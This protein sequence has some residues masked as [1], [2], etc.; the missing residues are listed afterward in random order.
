MFYY[1]RLNGE[2]LI[3]DKK[4]DIANEISEDCARE[5]K[6]IVYMLTSMEPLHSRMSFCV[7][8]PSLAFLK[9]EGLKLLRKS[10]S[11]SASLPGWLISKIHSGEVCSVNT[12]Y[13][14]WQ[15]ALGYSNPE[16]WRINVVGLGDVGGTLVTGLR[17]LGGEDISKIGLYD[18]DINKVKRWVFEAG[19]IY[20]PWKGDFPDV[21]GIDED[22]IFDCD[23]FVFCVSVG[24]PPVGSGISDV[25]MAQFEGNSRVVSSYAE[26]AAES[27]FRGIFAVVSDPVDLLCK[28]AYL[29]GGM[30]TV[31]SS[32]S[33]SLL[34][35]QIRGYGLGVMNARAAFYAAK[36]PETSH[37][38]AQ[39]R[40]YGPHGK[41]LV[42]ADSI[43]NYN[44][45]LSL[46]LTDMAQNANMDIRS[47]GF[48]PYVAPALSSGALSILATIRG[49]WHY[50]ATFMGGTYMGAKNRLTKAGT[51]V[52][53]LNIPDS[54]YNRLLNT[55]EYLRSII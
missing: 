10:Y 38:A 12:S 22:K 31:E 32:G 2:T 44:E 4:I 20:A 7:S 33:H 27:G 24:V 39:G 15:D 40:A 26:K 45:E 29:S 48:K 18:R 28:A 46:K 5:C 23:M 50:S 55:Y 25:R 17:L 54:L 9:S 21:A 19:Q 53:M 14:S 13:S 16:K 37:Y 1:Y 3:S 43:E 41:G 42:I 52:E 36:S 6:D 11:N 8:D 34:P 49:E 30:D 35:E 47:A 51:E